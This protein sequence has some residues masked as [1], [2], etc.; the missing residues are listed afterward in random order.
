MS[1]GNAYKTICWF[2]HGNRKNCFSSREKPILHDYTTCFYLDFN[3]NIY[4]SILA[5]FKKGKN[6]E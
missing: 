5:N 1:L 2:Y 6:N 4:N 3:N